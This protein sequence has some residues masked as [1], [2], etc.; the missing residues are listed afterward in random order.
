MQ[1]RRGMDTAEE[2]KGFPNY[3][4]RLTW[5]LLNK[6]NL[7]C[8]YCI[9]PYLDKKNAEL[10]SIDIPALLKFLER[11]EKTFRI[12]FTGGEPFLVPNIIEACL[13]ITEKHYVSFN[14]NLTSSR[15]K[16]FADKIDPQRVVCIT[17]TAHIK[18]LER[19]RLFN[20]YICHVLMLREKGFNVKNGVIA[21]PALVAEVSKYKQLFSK[22]GIEP[23]FTPFIGMYKNKPYPFS[24][25]DQELEIFRLGDRFHLERYYYQRKR[26]CNAGYNVAVVD[27]R[28][29]IYVCDRFKIKIGNIYNGITFRKG[30]VVCPFKFCGCPLGEMESALLQKALDECGGAREIIETYVPLICNAIE[31][32]IGLVGLF[33]RHRC[34]GIYF[35]YKRLRDGY[36][37]SQMKR[38]IVEVSRK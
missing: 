35:S 26:V 20:E 22:K 33:L 11:T 13:R 4:A 28:G 37:I 14:T 12:N 19:C 6:C 2:E 3:N 10:P 25:T 38:S 24:Y 34:P 21:Y 23:E 36:R 8:T 7:N 5:A 18:E 1:I 15:V 31:R 9:N 16:D 29:D 27:T 17:A 32:G 30:L